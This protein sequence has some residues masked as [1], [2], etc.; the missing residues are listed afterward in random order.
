MNGIA[1]APIDNPRNSTNNMTNNMWEGGNGEL[2]NGQNGSFTSPTKR[3]PSSWLYD[4]QSYDIENTASLLAGSA[5]EFEPFSNHTP[6]VSSL[7][8]PLRVSDETLAT[9]SRFAPSL[10]STGPAQLPAPNRLIPQTN[11]APQVDRNWWKGSDEIDGLDRRTR[12]DVVLSTNVS[13]PVSRG[14][15]TATARANSNTISPTTSRFQQTMQGYLQRTLDDATND[16]RGLDIN[17]TPGSYDK[18][19]Y[20]YGARP[21]I[22]NEEDLAYWNNQYNNLGYGRTNPYHEQQY[23]EHQTMPMWNQWEAS[24]T[25]IRADQNPDNR[26][27]PSS[28]YHA[29]SLTPSSGS[30]SIRSAVASRNSQHEMFAASRRPFPPDAYYSAAYMGN[31]MNH[32]MNN[33]MLIHQGAIPMDISRA[34]MNPLATP[35]YV[36]SY[37]SGAKSFLPRDDQRALVARS[38]FLEQFRIQ[39]ANKRYELRDLFGHIVEFSGDQHGSRFIQHKLETANSDEKERVFQEIDEDALQLMTDVFGNYVIQK[40]FEHGSQSQKKLLADKM[41]GHIEPLS[42]QMYGCRVV[43]KALDHVLTDQ[44]A[45]MV[46]ELNMPNKGILKVIKDQNGNHV[47][48]KAIERVPAEHIQFIIDAHKGETVKLAQHTYGCRVI[49]RILEF[50]TPA[51]KRVILDELHGCV[52]PLI[53]DQFGNYGTYFCKSLVWSVLTPAVIQHVISRGEPQDRRRVVSIVM[54]QLMHF[55]KHKF[56]SNVVEKSL[57]HADEDQ[58]VRMFGML[59]HP[60][61][62]NTSPVFG[63]LRDQYGNYV[64][65]K[66]VP[67][68]TSEYS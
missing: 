9:D 28:P 42:R 21:I 8:R 68:F 4:S 39:K 1:L 5:P 7:T 35:Y 45:S 30:E 56:A 43:Q 23:Y 29:S 24:D 34:N 11:V 53:T 18:P 62:S 52:A 59:I 51:A 13:P 57:E 33:G 25:K 19:S 15:A 66:L 27:G 49:Q 17:K 36:Q 20:P 3:K 26:N 50:C 61:L 63:L 67:G 10:R 58:Q 38:P 48:Q 60:D 64:I 32:S 12:N 47:V 37:V 22:H 6:E 31:G 40:L 16:F 46:E 55:S 2:N 44:Q 65:R 14:M 41:K 54:Q